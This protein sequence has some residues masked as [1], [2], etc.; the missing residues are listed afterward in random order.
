VVVSSSS[1]NSTEAIQQVRKLVG[2]PEDEEG[3][4]FTLAIGERVI[5]RGVSWICLRTSNMLQVWSQF[6]TSTRVFIEQGNHDP[7]AF[8]TEAADST[9][10]S[11]N[12]GAGA[13]PWRS[14]RCFSVYLGQS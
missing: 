8:T 14:G 11:A 6:S 10:A 7:G 13:E 12:I 1:G 4:S 3:P 2:E 5:D 9:P